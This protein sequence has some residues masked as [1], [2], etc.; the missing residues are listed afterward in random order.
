MDLRGIS[1]FTDFFVI[2]SGT[3]EPH[4]K[5]ITGAVSETVREKHGASPHGTSGIPSSQ[6]VVI[7]Y[8]DV[9]VHALH[10]DKREFYALDDLWGDAPTLNWEEE[11][12]PAKTKSKAKAPKKAA[13]AKKTAVK[14]AAK[15]KAS[16]KA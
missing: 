16:K 13:P 6:W 4:L 10:A 9:I 2:C 14:A 5:A 3:S 11:A 7:D 12:A 1:S 8:V 15:P